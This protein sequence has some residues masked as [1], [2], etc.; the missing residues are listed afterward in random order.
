MKRLLAVL[1]V[2]GCTPEAPVEEVP[3]DPVVVYVAYDED[4]ELL[5]LFARFQDETGIAITNRHGDPAAIVDDL[6]RNDISPSADV[7]MTRSVEGAWRAAD[8]GALRPLYSDTLRTRVPTWARDDDELWFATAADPAVIAYDP[9]VAA[10]S[11]ARSF[12]AL[13]EPTFEGKLCLSSSRE[14]INQAVIAMMIAAEGIRSSELVVRGWVQN[15]ATGPLE[16]S[17]QLAA[18][19]ASGSCAA[20]ILPRSVA[21]RLPA[22]AFHQPQPTIATIDVIGAGRH[23]H[24]PAGAAAFVDWLVTELPRIPTDQGEFSDASVAGWYAE[25]VRKLVERARYF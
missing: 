13:A 17:E 16:S 15:L 5:E 9:N 10:G 1:L 2:A 20:G 24:N 7:L 6:I 18:A 19:I 8:E 4:P 11:A 23:A 3:A 25:D 21:E 22:L 12:A 14:P